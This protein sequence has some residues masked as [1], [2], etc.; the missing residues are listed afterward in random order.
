MQTEIYEIR[1][2]GQV[3]TEACQWIAKH[4]A[5]AIRLAVRPIM[6]LTFIELL[7]IIFVMDT[8][9]HIIIALITSV[10][11]PTIPSMMMFV[12]EHPE[13]TGYPERLPKLLELRRLWSNYFRSAFVIGIIGYAISILS[14]ATM[15]GP[16]IAD[17]VK[18]MALVIHH[19][20]KEDGY[21]SAILNAFSLSF[22]NLAD[23]LLMALGN[24]II[25]LSV[26][27]GPLLMFTLLYQ[28]TTFVLT[29]GALEIL[30]NVL[31]QDKQIALVCLILVV[32]FTFGTMISLIIM[33]FFYGHCLLNS[34]RKKAAREERR[35]NRN[36]E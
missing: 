35:K 29:P 8:M 20:N 16:C 33:H 25:M 18:N 4:R 23:F 17:I 31:N 1:S 28:Y 6:L 13:E 5:L 3:V 32:G 24:A 27:I 2:R 19:R 36:D 21:I 9:T 12:V 15:V 30:N 11:I 34:E 26:L 10:L 7:N 22:S 14:S